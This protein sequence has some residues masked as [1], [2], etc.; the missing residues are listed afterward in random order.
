MTVRTANQTGMQHV[1]RLAKRLGVGDYPNYLSISLGAGDTTVMKMTN[2]FAILANHGRAL[3]PSLID[4]IQDRNGKVITATT[5]G[6]AS[7][8]T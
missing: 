3:K 8:A 2:A 5:R 1:T 4:Y 6:R 7:A